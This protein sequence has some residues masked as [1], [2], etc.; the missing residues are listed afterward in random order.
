MQEQGQGQEQGEGEEEGE[1]ELVYDH[2]ELYHLGLSG[3][4]GLRDV[5]LQLLAMVLVEVGGPS[6]RLGVCAGASCA[7][8]ERAWEACL[9]RVTSP[10][11]RM[12]LEAWAGLPDLLQLVCPA[13]CSGAGAG[14]APWGT[15]NA[16]NPLP[17]FA[18]LPHLQPYCCLCELNVSK[19]GLGEQ[20]A[21]ALGRAVATSGSLQVLDASWNSLGT[22]GAVV[23]AMGVRASKQV[24][25]G[26]EEADNNQGEG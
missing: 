9:A 10:H 23:L 26:V 25:R 3:N 19:C 11:T 13:V 17:P 24:G 16:L 4:M 12:G 15:Q 2:P 22:A 6:P 8:A 18:P 1:E 20:S 7:A 21:A 5:G 14:A